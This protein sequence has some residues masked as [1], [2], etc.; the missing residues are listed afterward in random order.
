MKLFIYL[1]VSSLF[2][3]NI[4]FGQENIEFSKKNFKDNVKALNEAKE[5]I[6]KGDIFYEISPGAYRIALQFY[7]KAYNFNQENSELNFKIGKCYL[8]TDERDKAID[9]LKKSFITDKKRKYPVEYYIAKAHH[10][11]FKFN[12]AIE[13]YN[14][15]LKTASKKNKKKFSNP[16]FKEIAESEKAKVSVYDTIAVVNNLG[17]EINSKYGDYSPVLSS[18]DNKLYFTSRRKSSDNK[19]L[20]FDSVDFQYFEDVY[21]GIYDTKSGIWKSEGSLLEINDKLSHNAVIYKIDTVEIYYRA[22]NSGDLFFKYGN[23]KTERF[24]EPIN[25]EFNE[26]SA[27]FSS[28]GKTLFF[29]SDRE[30]DNY[31]GKDIYFSEMDSTGIWG[32]AV[33]MGN[34]INSE[35]DEDGLFLHPR[36]YVL[37]FGSKGPGGIGGY[38]I[39]KTVKSD[40][41]WSNPVNIGY[42]IN[43]P[44]DDIHFGISPNCKTVFFASNRP[45]GYGMQDLY[46]CLLNDNICMRNSLEGTVT[47]LD[48]ETPLE[49][50]VKVFN[51]NDEVIYYKKSSPVDGSFIGAIPEGDNYT[52][53]ANAENYIVYSERINISDTTIGFTTINKQIKLT[54]AVVGNKIILGTVEFDFSSSV[55]RKSSYIALDNIAEYIQDNPTMNIEIGGHTDNKG[56]HEFNFELSESRAKAVVDYLLS[57]NISENRLTYKGYSFNKP[58]ADNETE[59]GRQKNRR[60]EFTIIKR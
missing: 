36:D 18:K 5:N 53:I 30:K 51:E 49:A 12:E 17:P 9:Y 37:F 54:K 15:F 60:V 11:N 52:L 10:Y 22:E 59:E 45:G 8:F 20:G 21:V 43:T 35:Y 57:K 38:D 2:I 44:Y 47:S 25:S 55:L 26:S 34:D 4:S 23:N 33:N 41:G 28:D 6:V 50:F 39:Y 46:T 40:S 24:P 16:V 19:E 58:L 3:S 48:D 13:S 1:F 14:N 27:V 42:P 32:A 31:G 56:T 7:L 29:V